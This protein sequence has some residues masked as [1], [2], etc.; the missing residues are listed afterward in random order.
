M[1]AIA[2]KEL[3][4][5][6]REPR[7]LMVVFAQP[8]ML[9]ILYGFCISFDLHD[10]PF[11]VWDQDRSEPARRLVGHIAAVAGGQTF[12]LQGYV[13]RPEE[14]EALLGSSRARFVL[15]IPRGFGKDLSAGRR[16]QVQALFDA[17]DSNTAGVAAGYLTGAVQEQSNRLALRA[18]LRL[19]GAARFT[20]ASLGGTNTAAA[21]INVRWRVFYNPDLSSRRYII[22][23]LIAV[24]LTFVATSLT[25]TTLVR[26]RELGS[27][28]SL[29]TSPVGAPELVL[30]KMAPYILVAAGNVALVL[31]A[32]GLVFNVWPRGNVVTLASFS[33][34]FLLGLLALGMLISAGAPNQQLALLL[35]T[36]ATLL[37]NFFL[38]GFAFPRS[39][40]PW[41]LQ[42]ISWPL[43]ATQYLIAIRGIFL[44]GIG[45]T[46]LWPQGLWMFLTAVFLVAQAIRIVRKSMAR[47]LG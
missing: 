8:L 33:F 6:L 25:S 47:G 16:V 41:I 24:L 29:L 36:L 2:E 18:M 38:T 30:G 42:V 5:L 35:A 19:H 37:P 7:T 40:M 13:S 34:L 20:G 3:R 12:V 26:E 21:P 31:V 27:L 17:A 4:H 28:E 39:N 43:P 11:A 15:V 9:L 46:V 32:G 10:L 22:P 1:R 23:G 14:I 44:K 45:W